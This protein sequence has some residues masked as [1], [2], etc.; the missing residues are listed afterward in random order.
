[1]DEMFS[2]KYLATGNRATDDTVSKTLGRQLVSETHLP[3]SME[4]LTGRK[5]QQRNRSVW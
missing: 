2:R 1:M 5:Q 3:K 4:L